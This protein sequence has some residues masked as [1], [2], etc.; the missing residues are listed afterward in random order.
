M[1]TLQQ[2]IN[3]LCGQP[4]SGVSPRDAEGKTPV[5]G[6]VTDSRAVMPDDIFVA[7]K[8][9]R[10]DAHDF[11]ADVLSKGALRA[12]VAQNF[13]DPTGCVTEKQLIRV[14]SP[15]LALGAL[16]SAYL[17]SFPELK[18][19]AITGS[20]GK[21]TVKEMVV[22]ILQAHAGAEAVH[23]TAGNFNNDIGLP[24]T[25]LA[26]GSVHRFAVFEMGMNHFGEIDYLSRL[27]RPHVA[28]VN[29]AMRA[30]LGAG[31]FKNTQDVARAKA[32]IFPHLVPTGVAILNADDPNVAVF[33]QASVAFTELTFG[34]NSP[35]AN[36]FASDIRADLAEV[37]FQLNT[38][39]GA[40]AIQ[41]PAAGE[42]N[43]RNACAAA[44]I[45]L[46]LDVPLTTVAKGLAAYQGV[47][48]RLQLKQAFNGACLIDDTYNANP[49]SMKAGLSVLQGYPAPR[50]LVM[51]DLGELG[52]SAPE[53]HAE[54]GA[55][56]WACGVEQLVTLGEL[57]RF[58]AAAFGG[59]SRSF[60]THAQVI[61][62][63]KTA[64]PDTA[65]VLIKGSRS[66]SMDTIVLGLMT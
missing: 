42:H 6:I 20:N 51:G 48:G 35:A 8:G 22:S 64:L 47:K 15:L 34:L 25:A 2:V 59:A 19:V 9:E 60:E 12:I 62:F 39:Q 21:T 1:F 41:L 55:F 13:V 31:G 65:T 30:H 46:A 43:V 45:A 54:V 24:L 23:A 26:V 32:E 4:F 5:H 61:E 27:V 66:M 58:A 44:A 28:L 63:M 36:L 49:D 16:A 17:A 10:F 14:P 57:S 38:P 18:R 33:Q 56:A 7:L 50:W 40:I 53:L 11:V 37:H 3:T 52:D 29:N